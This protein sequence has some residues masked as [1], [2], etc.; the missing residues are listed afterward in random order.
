MIEG[1]GARGKGQRRTNVPLSPVPRAP[2][3]ASPS[4]RALIIGPSNIGDAILTISV[5]EA[6]HQR[7]PDAHLTLII[8]ERA[9]SLFTDDPRIHTLVDAD[10]YDSWDGRAKL[11]WAL[12]RYQPHVFVDLRHTLYPFL[13]KPFQAWRY[14]KQPPR[15]IRHM[16]ER[17]WWKLCTQV[18]E[19]AF[20]DGSIPATEGMWS[21]PRDE[22]AVAALCRR[23]NLQAGVPLIVICPGARSH[24]KR[25][26]AEGFAR[27]ADRLIA[28]LGVQVVFSG[29]TDEEPVIE[30]IAIRMRQRAYSAV[31][32]TTIRQLGVLMRRVS[33]VIT[34]DS[35]SVHLASALRIPTVAIFG[36]TDAAKYGPTAPRSRTVRRTLFCAPCEQA[37]CR[38]NHECMRFISADEVF[39]AAKTLLEEGTK[40]RR[41]S[42]FGVRSS[43]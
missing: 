4:Q 19:A 43:E 13:L 29:E 40:R 33:L 41:S 30:E 24:I 23:W 20:D 22:Q 7:Y 31:S 39:N 21:S 16:R 11:A 18:P 25:W 2:S 38:F 26:T 1:Q 12:W 15:T 27:V 10:A 3:P 8:G 9:T 5:I 32:L 35:A 36:P 28:E 17:H 37:L 42:E 6:V 34:N 14:L